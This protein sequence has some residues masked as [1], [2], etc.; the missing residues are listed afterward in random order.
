[1]DGSMV[2]IQIAWKISLKTNSFDPWKTQIYVP[3]TRNCV[4]S[5]RQEKQAIGQFL[6]GSLP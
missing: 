5:N 3:T 1:M 2:L 4:L 6:R